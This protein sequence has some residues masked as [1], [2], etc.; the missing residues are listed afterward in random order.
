MGTGCSSIV[1]NPL[2]ESKSG[3]PRCALGMFD[4]SARSCVPD[5]VLT[6]AVPMKRFEEMV[7]NMDE[8]FLTTDSWKSVK[9]RSRPTA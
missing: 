2:M 4:V 3:N 8:S 9:A 1:G 5:N 7:G 6:F